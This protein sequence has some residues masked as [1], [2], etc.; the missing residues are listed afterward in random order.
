MKYRI[1]PVYSHPA[2]EMSRKTGRRIGCITNIIAESPPTH[3]NGRNRHS[4]LS[5]TMDILKARIITGIHN[6]SW[7]LSRKEYSAKIDI[8]A[9]DTYNGD[10]MR[11]SITGI[12]RWRPV[13]IPSPKGNTEPMKLYRNQ[14]SVS[15]VGS[16]KAC[17]IQQAIILITM[18]SQ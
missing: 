13:K 18:I 12:R 2:L 3:S 1:S 10:K 5:F 4:G 7:K 8:T 9:M 6:H 16:H 14:L 17:G 15:L 11:L